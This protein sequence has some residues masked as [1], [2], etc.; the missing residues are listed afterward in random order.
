MERETPRA[1]LDTNVLISALL[2]GGNP[3]QV[4]WYALKRELIG[5]TSPALLA[6]LSGVLASSKFNVP[7]SL[8]AL[9]EQEIRL[10]FDIVRPQ[11]ELRVLADTPDNRV[12]EAAVA[13]RCDAIVT[14]DRELL[15]LKKFHGIEIVTSNAFLNSIRLFARISE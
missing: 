13:G 15:A 7:G 10:W 6:E 1:V 2:Y 5:V 11:E 14:G 4:F 12:L 8:I 9:Y 3:E